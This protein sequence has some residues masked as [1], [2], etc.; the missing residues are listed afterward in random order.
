MCRAAVRRCGLKA[1]I[2]TTTGQVR[3]QELNT[4]DEMQAVVGGYIEPV[5]IPARD[6]RAAAIV[7]VNEE[8]ILNGLP[9]NR[10]A[11]RLLTEAVGPLS[12]PIV[13]DVFVVSHAEEDFGDVPK[14]VEQWA[15]ANGGGA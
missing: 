14:W 5:W 15:T 11:E 1:I 2:L 9:R 7:V 12:Q 8:G 6:G 13:G 3:Q 10:L 4:L